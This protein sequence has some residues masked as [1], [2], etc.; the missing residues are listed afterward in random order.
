MLLLVLSPLINCSD[1]AIM[2]RRRCTTIFRLPT[3]C[4]VSA[5]LRAGR[6]LNNNF[7]L[8]APP[9][10]ISEGGR[11]EKCLHHHHHSDTN[12]HEHE[13]PFEIRRRRKQAFF[14]KSLSSKFRDSNLPL[15]SL[16]KAPRA[17]ARRLF[18]ISRDTR[19]VYESPPSTPS[20]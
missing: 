9:S 2:D 19:I 10:L 20:P 13:I 18:S 17:G 6:V 3:L 5:R 8:L 16:C 15:W 12:V 11:H 4:Q 1:Y 14:Y 7:E